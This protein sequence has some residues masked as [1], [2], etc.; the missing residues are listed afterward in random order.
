VNVSAEGLV[1]PRD[2]VVDPSPELAARVAQL[3]AGLHPSL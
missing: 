2:F 1:G 3:F